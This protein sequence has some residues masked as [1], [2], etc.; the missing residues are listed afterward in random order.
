MPQHDVRSAK[1]IVTSHAPY[2]LLPI[3]RRIYHGYMTRTR[4]WGLPGNVCMTLVHLAEHPENCEP[5]AL[6]RATFCPRQTMTFILDV[7]E[8][9]GL[10]SRQ[11]HPTDRRRKIIR[12]SA[13]G[14][15]LA[16]RMLQNAQDIEREILRVLGRENAE[17][18]HTLL[19]RYAAA[20]A[21]RNARDGLTSNSLEVPHAAEG[22]KIGKRR[23][24]GRG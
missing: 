21:A 14:Q 23:T 13:K 19:A 4:L 24:E 8:E 17:T 12:L 15:H 9:N 1:N 16:R 10:A 11:P 3:W 5:A 20:L 6:A 22:G 2:S 18:L 7:L